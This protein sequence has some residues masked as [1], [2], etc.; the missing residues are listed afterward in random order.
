MPVAFSAPSR[1]AFET[2]LASKEIDLMASSFP[3]II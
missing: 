2:N 1:Q 3:G